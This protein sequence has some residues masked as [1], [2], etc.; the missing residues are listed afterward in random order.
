M[1]LSRLYYHIT[2]LNYS[3]LPDVIAKQRVC[4][5]QSMYHKPIEHVTAGSTSNMVSYL[6][7]SCPLSFVLY[8]IIVVIKCPHDLKSKNSVLNSLVHTY[9]IRF[10]YI[11]LTKVDSRK[12]LKISEIVLTRM[13]YNTYIRFYICVYFH[14][15]R[16]IVIT[17]RFTMCCDKIN[18]SC[19]TKQQLMTR[20]IKLNHLTGLTKIEISRNLIDNINL[21]S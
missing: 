1:T 15:H 12:T 9:L 11:H 21:M 19:L 7:D 13:F 17:L 16:A 4:V 6:V 3:N 2:V 20:N 5:W 8:S 18:T 10:Q 14:W